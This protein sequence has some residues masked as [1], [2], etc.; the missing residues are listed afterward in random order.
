[1][2]AR[3]VWV[4]HET[5]TKSI[6]KSI[7]VHLC[8]IFV[9]VDLCDKD[10]SGL[11]SQFR[12]TETHKHS[13]WIKTPVIW[14]SYTFRLAGGHMCVLRSSKAPV[15]KRDDGTKMSCVF[16]SRQASRGSEDKERRVWWVL[17]KG[18]IKKRNEKRGNANPN[19]FQTESSFDCVDR[20]FS[21]K[22]VLLSRHIH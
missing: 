17:K 9:K 10:P 12:P 1:M 8:A 20:Y 21:H 13:C 2:C 18:G 22:H 19:K 14:S 5:I 11:K 3:G 15:S 4:S 16:V 6:G 7:Y